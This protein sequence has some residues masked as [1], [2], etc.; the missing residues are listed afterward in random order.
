MKEGSISEEILGLAQEYQATEIILGQKT[1]I[2]N[3]IL[4][5]TISQTVLETSTIP[6]ML[7][8]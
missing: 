7:V 6:V 3:P 2:S 1:N 8:K 5:D 4:T